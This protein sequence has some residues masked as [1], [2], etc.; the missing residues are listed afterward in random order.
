MTVSHDYLARTIERL[1][2][3]VPVSYRRIFNGYGVYH[4]GVQFAIIVNNQLYFR[5][6]ELSRALYQA[7]G[8]LPFQ[9]G[10]LERADSSFYQ[11]PGEVLENTAELMYWMRT[12]VDA[13]EHGYDDAEQD[14]PKIDLLIRQLRLR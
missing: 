7:K 14:E 10:S 8:M 12:A 13:A 11:L 1:A 9:P 4:R 5:A 2:N 3:V 6:D